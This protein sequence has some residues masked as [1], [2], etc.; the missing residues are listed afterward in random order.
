M[1]E[2]GQDSAIFR[3]S[4]PLKYRNSRIQKR[5]DRG[6]VNVRSLKLFAEEAQLLKDIRQE[7]GTVEKFVARKWLCRL[8]ALADFSSKKTDRS[9]G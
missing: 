3:I 6:K 7:V 1:K 2:R 9:E 5:I 4:Q 8:R